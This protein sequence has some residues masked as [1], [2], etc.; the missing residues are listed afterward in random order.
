MVSRGVASTLDVWLCTGTPSALQL[1]PLRFQD[2]AVFGFLRIRTFAKNHFRLASRFFAGEAAF[3]TSPGAWRT[4]G[5]GS[6]GGTP[7]GAVRAQTLRTL[8]WATQN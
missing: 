2:E 6:G 8:T 1:P 3:T 4:N 7:A 5:A